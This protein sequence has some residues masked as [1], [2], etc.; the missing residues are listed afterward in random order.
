[1]QYGINKLIE[2]DD[3]KFN[4][5][6]KKAKYYKGALNIS[7]DNFGLREFEEALWAHE[8][9]LNE[10]LRVNIKGKDIQTPRRAHGKDLFRWSIEQYG[11]GATLVLNGVDL[12]SIW[13][14]HIC[15]TLDVYFEGITTANAFLTPKLSQG[16]QPHFD[17]HDI[18]VVQTAGSKIWKIYHQEIEEPTKNQIY[19]IDQ[20]KLNEPVLTIKLYPGDLLYVPRGFVHVAETDNDFSL[21]VTLGIRPI[22][23]VDLLSATLDVIAEENVNLRKNIITYNEN[24]RFDIITSA[25]ENILHEI[26]RPYIRK[27]IL[28]R[29]NEVFVSQLRPIA[30]KHLENILV[31]D[32]IE[33]DTKVIRRPEAI[34]AISEIEDKVFLTFPGIGV[35]ESKDIKPGYLIFPSL[36]Y[37]IL[38]YIAKSNDT[39]TPSDI[40]GPLSIETKIN[41]VKR[42]TKDGV[43]RAN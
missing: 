34:C 17:T 23:S 11:K 20:N 12:V 18:F 7:D 22:K 1:M 30:G 16:F 29:M 28:N 3:F 42:L 5:L 24:E 37:A 19:H 9:S 40:P 21:H 32:Y 14:A 25:F 15:R 38:T 36:T 41:I 8:N 27:K 39:F 35:T 6:S 4:V 43:L 31:S 26:K 33:K 10:R 2:D 13:F